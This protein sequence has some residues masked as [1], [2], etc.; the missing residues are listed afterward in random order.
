MIQQ[1]LRRFL[2]LALSVVLVVTLLPVISTPALAAVSGTL[3]GLSNTDITATYTGNGSASNTT[4]SA[5]SNSINGSVI[6]ESGLCS[7]SQYNTTLTI[8]NNKA[9]AA[10]LSFNYTIAQ[11]SGTIQV[12]GSAVTANGSYSG[13]LESGA[14][15]S[16]YLASGSTAN[17]TKIAITDLFLIVD[18]EITTTFIPAENGSYTVDGAAISAETVRTQ[19]ST[20]AYSLSATANS[21][22]EF[23][24]WYSV[25]EDRYLS[26]E[27][28]VSLYFDSS[29]T[30]TAMFTD[31][32]NPIFD[33]GGYK[34]LDLNAANSYAVENRIGKITVV[35]NGTLPSGEYTISTG[36][37][38][39]IPFDQTE[40]YYMGNPGGPQSNAYTRPTTPF[41]KLT[42]ADGAHI[43]VEGAINVSAMQSAASGAADTRS[44]TTGAYG[45]LEMLPGSSILVKSGGQ[46]YVYGYATGQGTITAES[47]AEVHELFEIREFRGGSNTS[48]MVSGSVFP[49]S[50]YYVQ[51]IEAPLTLQ[52]GAK[53]WTYAAIWA[54]SMR[55]EAAVL[56]IGA[57]GDEA[58][59]KLSNGQITK[60]YLPDSDRCQIDIEGDLEIASVS[61]NVYVQVDSSD[62]VLPINSQFDIN[63]LSGTT[64]ITEN[65]EFL[66]GVRMSVAEGAELAITSGKS[67]YLYDRDE[68]YGKGYVFS[69]K[70]MAAASYSPTRTYTRTTND[71]TDVQLDVNGTVNV[72]GFLFTTEGGADITTSQ[73]TGTITLVAT[74]TTDIGLEQ[75]TG[76]R[77]YV[78]VP[79]TPAKLHNGNAETPYTETAGAAA[80][81][82]YQYC[83]NCDKWYT[84]TH[85]VVTFVVDG[86]SQENKV[87]SDADGTVTAPLAE[88]PAAVTI[89]GADGS[90]LTGAASSWA[91]GTLTVTG[92]TGAEATVTIVTEST[93]QLVNKAGDVVEIYASLADAVDAYSVDTGYIQLTADVT[94]DVTIGKNIYLD[95]AGHTLD[96]TVTISDG[97]TLY[98][99][100]SSSDGV[101]AP[102]GGIDSVAGTGTVAVFCE[103]PHNEGGAYQRYAAIQGDDGSSYTFHCF[104]ISVTGYRFE[105]LSPEDQ[106]ALIF[107]GIFR[108]DEAVA[109]KLDPQEVSAYLGGSMESLPLDSIEWD[110]EA[111]EYRFQIYKLETLEE[112]V[113]HYDQPITVYAAVTFRKEDGE[114]GAETCESETHEWSWAQAWEDALENGGLSE[115]E[116]ANLQNF[117][118]NHGIQLGLPETSET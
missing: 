97:V 79:I 111:G 108:G 52:A 100:D 116:Q 105:I 31:A 35:S 107:L 34:F 3:T 69:N 76:G 20:I 91:D 113:N 42:L 44:A 58:L 73:G 115:E 38:L 89:T 12:A 7:D 30:V 66:A 86:A 32:G 68:W 1:I 102:T 118:T 99:M 81:T 117:L 22:Y 87:C 60:R 15:I 37:V 39:L 17:A 106:G 21:G 13:T 47:G 28:N 84:G 27:A 25:T 57:A 40:T 51:N 110:G 54:A 92:L 5:G 19:Q 53:L 83:T 2:S 93:A 80:G 16:I 114:S 26:S 90:V 72:Y 9:T 74:P 6:G 109:N 55:T 43:T 77:E 49:F 36:V 46:L 85:T 64:T 23:M 48:G 63:I 75:V 4:W 14:S 70:D 8:T 112:I 18:A 78:D 56:L 95:L 59:F 104:N 62:Y 29:Q 11:N 24:G 50:Q 33:V 103:T 71:L 88:N 101:A 94:G 65:M 45:Q 10:R 82:T 96:G 67:L 98:G 41:R 61:L